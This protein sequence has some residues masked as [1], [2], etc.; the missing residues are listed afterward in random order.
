MYFQHIRI[1][2]IL[3]LLTVS[4]FWCTI[5]TVYWTPD[6][7]LQ[8]WCIRISDVLK[9]WHIAIFK[10]IKIYI[11][12]KILRYWNSDVLEFP[13]I[14]ISNISEYPCN[15][16]WNFYIFG[17]WNFWS[18]RIIKIFTVLE[19][20]TY[21]SS[22]CIWISS[23]VEFLMEY[24]TSWN[25]WHIR[26]SNTLGFLTWWN[27][28]VLELPRYQVR[29][30]QNSDGSEFQCIVMWMHQI[31]KISG[32]FMNWNSQYTGMTSITD[33]IEFPMHL[34]FWHIRITIVLTYRI[35][36]GTGICNIS[37]FQFI[38]IPTNLN[39]QC[40]WIHCISELLRY[41]NFQCNGICTRKQICPQN[42]TLM[43]Y[44]WHAYMGD[45]CNIYAICE[46]T[47]ITRST[48]HIFDITLNK[49]GCH[50]LHI[51]HTANMLDGN[52]DPTFLHIYAKTQPTATSPLHV[53][54]KYVQE[55]N[56]PA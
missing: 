26:I 18:I 49:H 3:K 43:P 11:Y 54:A 5:L 30:Y 33:L 10:H 39:L 4:E 16:N 20:L 24:L 38:S 2:D 45:E 31:P 25:F 19:I 13:C 17:I 52:I 29:T 1:S 46:A 15:W 55:T 14:W 7:V 50:T 8:F 21:W 34:N 48:V 12:V 44:I 32:L 51:A 40:I 41:Q 6:T 42:L 53:I 47:A 28:N 37:E 9:S 56:I 22:L 35:V 27:F 36:K 23:L